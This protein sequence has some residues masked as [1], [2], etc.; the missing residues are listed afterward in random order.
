MPIGRIGQEFIV[1]TA[2]AS[3][4][5]DPS[6]TALADG[7][8][9]VTYNSI[10]FSV[11]TVRAR[12][13]NADGSAAGNDF[14]VNTTTATN[15]SSS[16]TALADGRFVVTWQSNSGA[17]DIRSRIINADGS[18]D[19]TVNM[20]FDFLVNT[21]TANGQTSPSVTALADGRFVVT[22]QSFDNGSDYDIRSQIFDPTVF[23]GT[24]SEDIW[25][26]SNVFADRIN[27][28]GGN[29]T[30]SGLGGDDLINGDAGNDILNGGAGND[31]LFG[32]ADNDILDGGT[33]NDA[34]A[35]GA[36]NDIY[37]VS[38]VG[39]QTIEAANGGI[40]TVRS[41]INWTLGACFSKSR[42]PFPVSPGH[43]FH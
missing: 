38:A 31:R 24:S 43:R 36:G 19:L 17:N 2:T 22:W 34:I 40:D 30:L 1:N 16:V 27:G 15:H 35:G 41:Y 23:N 8:F 11:H 18:P 25:R 13:F 26:G 9:V 14:L 4:Q 6:I 29:D 3:H 21:T 7:R 33:G 20:G 5:S 42:T 10:D 32:G 39:D 37:I 28:G 12:I